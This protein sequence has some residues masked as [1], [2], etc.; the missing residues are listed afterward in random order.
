MGLP[1]D[2]DTKNGLVL[3]I[4]VNFIKPKALYCPALS[5]FNYKELLWYSLLKIQKVSRKAELPHET[6]SQHSFTRLFFQTLK[7]TTR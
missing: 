5:C 7:S 4:A 2:Q 6:K 1:S 3:I